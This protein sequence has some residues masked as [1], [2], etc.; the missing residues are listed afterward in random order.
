M[1]FNELFAWRFLGAALGAF[2][3]NAAYS[4]V[5]FWD[6]YTVPTTKILVP[7]DRMAVIASVIGCL[8]MAIGGLC[9]LT[10]YWVRIGAILLVGFL[11]GGT[12]IHYRMEMQAAA[13]QDAVKAGLASPGAENEPPS[14]P[15][16]ALAELTGSCQGAHHSSWLKNLVLL[17]IALFYVIYGWAGPRSLI[18]RTSWY[19][20]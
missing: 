7:D 17:A 16:K 3:L 1:R 2:Y 5:Q 12:I 13:L 18:E 20:Y 19:S 15:V 11:A 9:Y 8:I 10:G 6:G 14:P 4:C